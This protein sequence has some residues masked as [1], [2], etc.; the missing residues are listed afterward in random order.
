[1]FQFA[2]DRMQSKAPHVQR[3]PRICEITPEQRSR[4]PDYQQKWINIAQY[5]VKHDPEIIVQAIHDAYG[6]IGLRPPQVRS[7]QSP[8]A[9]HSNF[10]HQQENWVERFITYL[11]DQADRIFSIWCAIAFLICFFSFFVAMPLVMRWFMLSINPL[12]IA[13]S[14]S[15]V[16]SVWVATPI[17]N[18]NFFKQLEGMLCLIF[19]MMFL[20]YTAILAPMAIWLGYD[21]NTFFAVAYVMGALSMGLKYWLDQ[22]WIAPSWKRKLDK[23]LK[24]S[25]HPQIHPQLQELFTTAA[26]AHWESQGKLIAQSTPAKHLPMIVGHQIDIWDWIA[27]CGQVDF[28]ISELGCECER[29]LW[30]SIQVLT[31]SCS[32]ILPRKDFC[33]VSDRPTHLHFDEQQKLHAEGQPAVAF[34]DGAAIYCIHG[35]R[36]PDEYS[37][38]DSHQWR[39]EWVLTETNAELRRILIQGIGYERLCQELRTKTIDT[40]R[41]YTLLWVEVPTLSYVKGVQVREDTMLLLKMTC[42]STN[43]IHVLRVPPNTGSARAAAKWVNWD[44]DPEAFAIE[45]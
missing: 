32:T 45:S 5:G 10:S 13:F 39:S 6:T 2:I 28:C 22:S 27:W 33:Y 9:L 35:V 1:M 4:I 36:L 23:Q 31:S 8:Y 20:I 11:S 12:T 42:P 21:L 18:R 14:T 29:T 43:H 40:W 37:G 19:A 38:L 17:T 7:F 44:I 34:A 30:N 16:V 26:L 3:K 41:E 15:I 24:L 25:I